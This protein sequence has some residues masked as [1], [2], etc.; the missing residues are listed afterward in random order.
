MRVTFE[1]LLPAYKWFLVGLLQVRDAEESPLIRISGNVEQLHSLYDAYCPDVDH[2]PFETIME[3][4]T[5]AFV[6][7][8]KTEYYGSRVVDWIHPSYRDLV[9]EELVQNADLRSTFLRRASLEGIKLAV[10]DTGGQHGKRRLPF[11]RSAESWDVLTERCLS[12]VADDIGDRD[13]LEVLGN[14]AS[15]SS[16]PEQASRWARLLTSVCNTI[17]AKW[18]AEP[19]VL[20]DRDL[21]AFAKARNYTDPKSDLPNVQNTWDSLDAQFRETLRLADSGN[22]FDYDPFDDLTAFAGVLEQCAPELLEQFGFPS[23]YEAEITSVLDNA[24][25]EASQQSYS[26]DPEKL[27]ELA[28]RKESIATSLERLNGLSIGYALKVDGLADRLKERSSELEEEASKYDPPE[29]DYDSEAGARNLDEVVIF[30]VGKLFS[31]L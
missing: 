29:P 30:E 5:E 23:K 24:E 17:R 12:L 26:D 9:I 14:A 18:D 7:V 3:H 4:L 11:I 27:R 1:K 2:E 25:T 28:Q 15:Q 21:E 6:K 8:R 13:V 19:R 20:D 22:E 16:S 10:S 31:E